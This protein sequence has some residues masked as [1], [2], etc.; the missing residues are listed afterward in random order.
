M[1]N[2]HRITWIMLKRFVSDESD[3]AEQEEINSWVSDQPDRQTIIDQVRTI[4]NTPAEQKVD[5][6]VDASWQR[7]LD[8]YGVEDQT[9]I[10]RQINSETDK[11]R[12]IEHQPV[13]PSRFGYVATAASIL[14]ICSVL[15]VIYLMTDRNAEL[16][17]VT[18]QEII[19]PRG[20][21]STLQLSDGS[22]VTLNAD[23]KLS[24]PSDFGLT[25]RT[26][27]LEGEGY[28]EVEHDPS[29]PF[30]VYTGEVYTEVLGTA[31][32]IKS[33]ED[34]EPPRV[35]V[36]V[37]EGLVELGK[38]SVN[39]SRLALL[40]PNQMGV[41]SEAGKIN[42]SEV[43]DLDLK[44]GWIN[45]LLVFD[46]AEFSEVARQLERRFNINIKVDD[47]TIYS[48]RL[49]ATFGPESLSEI[50]NVIAVSLQLEMHR[51][52]NTI[53]FQSKGSKGIH[54]ES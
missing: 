19:T 21:K 20:Q 16:P 1:S 50:L 45:G 29:K 31:F 8:R 34:D 12:I 40:N 5:W 33:Y 2:H 6:D 22:R 35:E 25:N 36:V 10:V 42:I 41:V 48:R 28:F 27:Y 9:P 44:I 49:T 30:R 46:N 13:R 14:L 54:D 52:K 51:E 47:E 18:M 7:Y 38:E 37:A 39:G 17:L 43:P 26:L 53:T 23:S 15:A 4:W 3:A 32:N 11:T 24:I